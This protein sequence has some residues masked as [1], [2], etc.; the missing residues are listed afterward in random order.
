MEQEQEVKTQETEA[1][2]EKKE[3]SEPEKP[4]PEPKQETEVKSESKPEPKP[5]GII[6]IIERTKNPLLDREEIVAVIRA[7]ITPSKEQT[8]KLLASELK[9]DEGLIIIKN[10]YSSFGQQEFKINA[11]L[12]SSKETF[13]KLKPVRKEKELE[14]KQEEE[15]PEGGEKEHAKEAKKE[16]K[17]E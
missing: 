12:Y 9:A 15:K 1:Q 8:K 7:T 14:K 13:E 2:P 3:S 17:T 5:A 10:I 11:F 16:E 4:K 6:E